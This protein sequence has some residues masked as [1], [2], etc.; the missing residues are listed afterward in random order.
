MT[1]ELTTKESIR[2]GQA[3]NIVGQA[4]ANDPKCDFSDDLY[5][6]PF[7]KEVLNLYKILTEIEGE[8]V[9]KKNEKKPMVFPKKV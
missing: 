6:D 1:E 5:L 4:Y 3:M 9:T 2:L 7:K 8:I